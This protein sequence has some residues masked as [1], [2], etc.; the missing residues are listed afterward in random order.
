MRPLEED[1]FSL[2]DT[3]LQRKRSKT[4]NSCS[5]IHMKPAASYSAS[6]SCHSS[7][8]D[9]KLGEIRPSSQSCRT[10][11]VMRYVGSRTVRINSLKLVLFY[12]GQILSCMALNA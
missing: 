3:R 5:A 11:K 8:L 10:N 7:L 9:G 4:L 12:F 6:V 1:I 2:R